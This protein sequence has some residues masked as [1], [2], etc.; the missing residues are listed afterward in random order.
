M[1]GIGRAHPEAPILPTRRENEVI[2]QVGPRT[3]AFKSGMTNGRWAF[4]SQRLH[5]QAPAS[6]SRYLA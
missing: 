2:T 6:P 5:C 1:R 4:T 3:P